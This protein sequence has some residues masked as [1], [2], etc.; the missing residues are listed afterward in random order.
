MSKQI[1]SIIIALFFILN[2][3]SL[4]FAADE[5]LTITT[6]YP[7]PYGSYYN[8]YVSNT[9]GI[10]TATP[11]A[12]F[13]V[14]VTGD[15]L[16]EV[17][18]FS[19]ILTNWTAGYGPRIA[20]KGGSDDRLFG[21]IDSRLTTTGSGCCADM[22]FSARNA[23]ALVERVRITSAGYVGINVAAPA[24]DL[25]V[26]GRIRSNSWT[27]D[28]AAVAYRSAAGDLGVAPS[29]RRLKKNITPITNSL[30]IVKKMSGIKYNLISEKGNENKSLGLIAQ[31]VMKVLP[32][33]VFSYKNDKGEIYY[34][35]HYDKIPVVLIEAIKEQ[36]KEIDDL[37]SEVAKFKKAQG[38]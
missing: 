8:L 1:K 34:G 26:N 31:D 19:S 22:V 17:A 3:S 13:Q 20:F 7:S 36:Q 38:K 24:V 14:K 4:A 11:A 15:G 2:L 6:Y 33:A 23:E 10:G 21:T 12:K 28:G 30:D 27:A 5:T 18:D 25:H 9:L 29:D 16:N 37:R 32:E 35:V